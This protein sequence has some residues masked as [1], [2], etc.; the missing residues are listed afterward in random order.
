VLVATDVAARGLHI[1]GVDIVVQY[2]PPDDHKT[3]LH[4]S[5]RTARAGAEGMVV[6]LMLWNQELQIRQL[7]RRLGIDEPMIEVFSNDDRLGDLVH[8]AP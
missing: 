8:L 7:H 2:D 4:R 6:T 5:G 3:Y 1:E